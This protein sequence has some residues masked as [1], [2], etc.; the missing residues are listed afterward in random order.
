MTSFEDVLR[1]WFPAAMPTDSAGMASQLEWWFGGGADAEITA[2][3]ASLPERAA[4]GELD[5]WAE[6]AL[7]RLALIIVLDQF[8]RT[9]FRGTPQAFAQDARAL[10]LARE[11]IESGAYET[12]ESPWERTFFLLPLSHSEELANHDLSVRL[13]ERLVEEAPA[14]LRKVLEFS[15]G[16][17]RGHR[18]II[19]RFGRHP[20][21]N[22]VLGRE[23]TPEE[24][25]YLAS[26]QLVHERRM[27][28]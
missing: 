17:A 1:F 25:Y 23:S 26:G 19:I 13:A 24:L 14:A 9:V 16:Q 4:R 27:R 10:A 3:F 2:R 5:A 22:A 12:L 6:G 28:G 15:A 7:S 18:D 11:G 21:R 20:H 8:S